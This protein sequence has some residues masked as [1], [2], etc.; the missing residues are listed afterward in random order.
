MNFVSANVYEDESELAE[1]VCNFIVS[2]SIESTEERGRFT[3]AVTADRALF[4][5]AR[6]VRKEPFCSFVNWKSW[7]IFFIDEYC[8]PL[9][10]SQSNYFKVNEELLQCISIPETQIFP[11]YDASSDLDEHGSSCESASLNYAQQ[12]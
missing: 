1:A 2:K 10:H 12:V 8:L 4:L 11:A 9:T 3:I 6:I 7:W 5:F